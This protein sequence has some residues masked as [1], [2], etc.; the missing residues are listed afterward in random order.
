MTMAKRKEWTAGELD[1]AFAPHTAALKQVATFPGV[2]GVMFDID[3]KSNMPCARV[4]MAK[5]G[6]ANDIPKQVG[7]LPLKVEFTR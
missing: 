6:N 7:G 1:A 3:Q 2:Q 5:G 4:V